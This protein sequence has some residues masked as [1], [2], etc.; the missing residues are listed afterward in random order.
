MFSDRVHRI[1]LPNYACSMFCWNDYCHQKE[2]TF[3]ELPISCSLFSNNWNDTCN[4]SLLLFWPIWSWF[5]YSFYFLIISYLQVVDFL[6][7]CSYLVIVYFFSSCALVLF[8]RTSLVKKV[9]IPSIIITVL[10]FLATSIFAI[11]FSVTPLN[12]LHCR[13]PTWLAFSVGEC[14]MGTIFSV[15]GILILRKLRS[16]RIKREVLD[17]KELPLL[18]LMIIFNISCFVGLGYELFVYISLPTNKCDL[19][20]ANLNSYQTA[21][22]LVTRTVDILVPIWAIIFLFRKKAKNNSNSYHSLQYHYP[23]DH[24]ASVLSQKKMVFFKSCKW[25]KQST[26]WQD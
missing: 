4:S 12:H 5:W 16:N 3:F 14:V 26:F 20:F 8:N 7:L 17:D 15:C 23:I 18:L 21:L 2:K 13:N 11:Y 10:L 1:E 9:V 24:G 6:K 22:F 19:Y 25:M